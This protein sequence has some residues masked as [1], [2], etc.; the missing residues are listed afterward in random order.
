MGLPDWN[1]KVLKNGSLRV[2]VLPGLGGKL[3]SISL[4]PEGGEFLQGPLKPYAPRTANMPFAESDGSGWDECL[5][6]VGPCQV[7]YGEGQ[8]ATIEDHG[9]LW[10][11]PWT[12]DEATDE[13]LRMHVAATSLPLEFTRTLTL[14]GNT[15]EAEYAVTNTG[16]ARVPYGWSIHPL[17]AVEP[18]D[19]IVL[20]PSVKE[21]KGTQTKG[22]LG[23]PGAT[24]PWPMTTNSLDREPLNLSLVGMSED[25]VGDKL[26]LPAP[27]EGWCA[28]E[29]VGL[30]SRL[31][32]H[33][34]P[35]TWPWLGLW[36]C[37]GGW[38]DGAGGKK[39]YAVG[40]E[41]CNL[42]VDSLAD[43]LKAG[44]GSYL[45]GGETRD[46]KLQISI[47]KAAER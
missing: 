39:G 15:I 27:A 1:R 43:S 13:E 7:S 6:S 14:N 45:E 16:T 18:F 44:A 26:L 40:I 21:V 3:S 19:C 46:W 38:P 17:F 2:E 28:L 10:R 37:Y 22:R 9:D 29:R 33:F 5:P 34:D 25:N 8:T 30:R 20:P 23:K 12:V 36:L 24:H 32:L 4:I 47:E 42:P 35:K 31:V 11:L 41:P